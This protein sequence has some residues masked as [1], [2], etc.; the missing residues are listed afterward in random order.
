MRVTVYL[1]GNVLN[2]AILVNMFYIIIF[3]GGIF[4]EKYPNLFRKPS[5]NHL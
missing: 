2:I 4:D 5:Y 3:L 1:C